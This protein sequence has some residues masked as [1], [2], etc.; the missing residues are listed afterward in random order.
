[1]EFLHHRH[2]TDPKAPGTV[3]EKIS[4]KHRE[5]DKRKVAKA[6]D[7]IST[8]FKPTKIPLREI[9]P[10]SRGRASSIFTAHEDSIYGKQVTADDYQ[11]KHRH[12]RLAEPRKGQTLSFGQGTPS[13]R[14]SARREILPRINHAARSSHSPSRI[15]RKAETYI[16]WSEGQLSHGAA[17][18]PRPLQI[19]NQHSSTPES[20]RRSLRNTGVYRDTGIR[21]HPKTQISKA[22]SP[23]EETLDQRHGLNVDEKIRRRLPLTEG[24]GTTTSSMLSVTRSSK[25]NTASLPRHKYQETRNPQEE[26]Y[27]DL[28]RYAEE[29][30]VIESG[31]TLKD[32]KA[33]SAMNGKKRIIIEHFDSELGWHQ[34]PSSRAQIE[35]DLAEVMEE[36]R[37]AANST[38]ITR[39]QLAKLA[40]VKRPATTLRAARLIGEES[41]KRNS[42]LI[43]AP[44][45]VGLSVAV[46][47]EKQSQRTLGETPPTQALPGASN[48]D[49]SRST[50]R[51]AHGEELQT[52]RPKSTQQVDERDS[53]IQFAENKVAEECSIPP[54]VK[55]RS[56]SSIQA[57]K[58]EITG[59]AYGRFDNNS[60]LGLPI[61]GGWNQ[62]VPTLS[63]QPVG[64]LPIEVEPLF[65]HQVQGRH[66]PGID[67]LMYENQPTDN[68]FLDI[69]HTDVESN[70]YLEN[71]PTSMS[72]YQHIGIA[73]D[74]YDQLLGL[75]ENDLIQ[76][77]DTYNPHFYEE[78]K[79]NMTGYAH[80]TQPLQAEEADVSG[81]ENFETESRQR[82]DPLYQHETFEEIPAAG[83]RDLVRIERPAE[84]TY[85]AF[86]DE[87]SHPLQGFWKARRQY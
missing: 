64:R 43:V 21:A 54:S 77:H 62:R 85:N 19:T 24:S 22:R 29:N 47:G 1:M 12:S 36:T 27:A 42:P 73:Q 2:H 53:A 70:L 87:S 82:Q 83:Q 71:P 48:A 15:S 76:P 39:E 23:S 58:T 46:P 80:E 33:N 60:Y 84:L 81:L 63:I 44:E 14:L 28:G 52:F 13:E 59:E 7:E 35:R 45:E 32:R 67:H 4:S 56:D 9:D 66:T 17:T 68:G 37:R 72:A 34:R 38:P 11:H 57:S 50:S 61:R 41:V 74:S 86:G 25:E 8:F 78:S 6:Q 26:T 79:E 3:P 5:K 16:T 10:N 51:K 20:I 31:V 30:H 40:R 65:I 69:A 18:A 55:P 75:Q 49:E